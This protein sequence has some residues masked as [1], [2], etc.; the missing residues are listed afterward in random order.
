M[1]T[2]P[3]SGVGASFTQTFRSYASAQNASLEV[4]P[5]GGKVPALAGQTGLFDSLKYLQQFHVPWKVR[6]RA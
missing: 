6:A 2:L 1:I 5:V 3:S 4:K